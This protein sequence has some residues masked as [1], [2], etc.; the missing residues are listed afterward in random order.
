MSILGFERPER[1][2]IVDKNGTIVRLNDKDRT[3]LRF[4]ASERLRARR[5]MKDLNN[6]PDSLLGPYRLLPLIGETPSGGTR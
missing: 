5:I 4:D 3:E 2:C 6:Y 1:L